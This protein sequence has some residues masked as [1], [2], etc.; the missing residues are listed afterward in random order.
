MSE[1]VGRT[2]RALLCV[3]LLLT[4]CQRESTRGVSS[5][6]PVVARVGD[7]V[8]TVSELRAS[9]PPVPVGLKISLVETRRR[10]LEEVVVLELSERIAAERDL[11]QDPRFLERARAIDREARRQK[12]HALRRLLSEQLVREYRPDPE[13]IQRYYERSPGRFQTTRVHLREIVTA[14]ESEAEEALLEIRGGAGFGEVARRRSRAPSARD[15][16]RIGPYTRGEVP[17]HLA[18]HVLLLGGPGT[19]G[20][21]VETPEGWTLVYLEK[22]ETDVPRE[23]EV[24]RPAIERIL[25]QREMRHRYEGAIQEARAEV[26]VSINET[27]LIDESYFSE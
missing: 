8:I 14:T 2:L 24:I 27:V 10:T 23:L 26:G 6:D 19:I 17:V 20:G 9:M 21:P 5:G 25:Q 1:P 4:A 15:G 18:P 7:R 22:R 13:E 16:G 12:Q 11:L 3:A